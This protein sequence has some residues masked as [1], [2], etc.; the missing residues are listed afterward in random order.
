MDE[1]CLTAIVN[2]KEILSCLSCNGCNW[3]VAYIYIFFVALSCVA[4]IIALW[5]PLFCFILFLANAYFYFFYIIID[6]NVLH[7]EISHITSTQI[8]IAVVNITI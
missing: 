3:Y 5:H 8:I 2:Q 7:F 1:L 4:S 6:M